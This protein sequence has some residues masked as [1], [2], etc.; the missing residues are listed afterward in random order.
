MESGFAGIQQEELVEREKQNGKQVN[1]VRSKVAIRLSK[2]LKNKP[3][4][5]FG[6]SPFTELSTL[7]LI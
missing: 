1:E 7:E 2:L 3:P 5:M 4:E 6:K